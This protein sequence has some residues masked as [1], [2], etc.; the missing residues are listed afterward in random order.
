MIAVLP[1][2]IC[3]LPGPTLPQSV[4]SPGVPREECFPLEKL[5]PDLRS[6]SE[7][8]LL[9]ALDSEALDNGQG[10]CSAQNVKLKEQ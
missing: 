6:K 9:K 10:R 4:K 5:P 2:I 3:L 8:L 7:R 1:V